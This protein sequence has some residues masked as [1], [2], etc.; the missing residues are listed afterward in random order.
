MIPGGPSSA[1]ERITPILNLLGDTIFNAGENPL[2]SVAVK[3]ANN[4]ILGC[5][6]EAMGE[7]MSLVRKYDVQPALF[8]EVLTK[9]LFNCI[10]YQ[11]YGDV[12]AK[13]DWGRVGATAT[14]GLKDAE[15]ALEA[16]ARVR[17]PLPSGDVWHNHLLSACG[18]GE[19]SL[20]WAVMA[21]EQFRHS[22]L[23]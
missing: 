10:A 20:D 19:E 21:R 2:S 17:V 4:F 13:E 1:I 8:Y 6:I 7:G 23:E 16:A 5:A 15:L 12:I 22:G 14:I 9:G 3:I 11:S 18:R